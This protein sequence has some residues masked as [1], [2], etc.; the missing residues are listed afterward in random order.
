[1]RITENFTLAEFERSQYAA[2][3]GIDNRAP[4]EAIENI[5]RLCE[6]ILQPLRTDRGPVH[7]SS[8]YRCLEL[9]KAIGGARRS[10]HP[11]GRA[12]DITVTG[13]TP[14]EVAVILRDNPNVDKVILEFGEWVH[15]QVSEPGR[16]P[17][18]EAYTATR[19]DGRTVYLPGIMESES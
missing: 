9:N 4:A 7:L 2:R 1:M 14:Y 3:H 11:T 13:L 15:V 17:R 5:R 16:A 6:L 10:A 18:R 19:R 12:S 8:G